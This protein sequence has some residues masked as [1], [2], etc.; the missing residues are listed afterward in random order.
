MRKWSCL[1]V[2]AL[3]VFCVPG[4]GLSAPPFLLKPKLTTGWRIDTNYFKEETNETEVHTYLVQPG[5]DL[6]YKTAK[7]LL[8]L[9][10]TLD[11]HYFDEKD[12]VPPGNETDD[13][14]G[15]T[16]SLKSRT[17]PF[18]RVTLGLDESY[19][20]TNVP[21]HTDIISN[22]QTRE[23]YAINRL[24]PRLHYEVGR[25]LTAG[26]RYRRTDLDYADRDEEDSTEHRGIFNLIYNL[27][28]RA[29]LDLQYQQW[30]MDYDLNTSDYTSDHVEL[31]FKKQFRYFSFAAG[32]GYHERDFEDPGIK[33]IDMLSYRLHLEGQNPPA[34]A[35]KRSHVRFSVLRDYNIYSESGDY[36][37][38]QR[39]ML[40]AGHVFLEKLPAKIIVAYQNSPYERV[41]G[42]TPSGNRREDDT[43]GFQASLGYIWT[44]WLTISAIAGY[45]E[46]DSNL[47]GFDYENEYFLI[48][49]NFS[50]NPGSN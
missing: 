46:R 29:S 6:G 13:L 11:A 30:E 20:K 48:N 15:H 17:K 49:L 23:E 36:Y 4:R 31:I 41:A 3:L 43:N 39:F 45:E 12:R 50:Y 27:S 16:L 32:G 19:Y 18:V 44:D 14:V 42:I 7:S 1:L 9:N 25:R 8:L 33:G 40:E 28:P 22:R 35:Q 38:A 10:Y 24:T 34:P 26:L 21:S 5:I 37:K 47:P 2:A